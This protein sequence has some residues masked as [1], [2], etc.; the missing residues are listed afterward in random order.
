[1]RRDE[2]PYLPHYCRIDFDGWNLTPLTI[3]NGG[4]S[5]TSSWQHLAGMK[6]PDWNVP[7]DAA[8]PGR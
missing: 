5:M 6:T 2:D 4:G 7:M 1:M 8:P 3:G